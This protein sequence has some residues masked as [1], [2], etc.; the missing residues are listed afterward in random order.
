MIFLL[1]ITFFS[2]I[3]W[4]CICFWYSFPGHNVP[5]FDFNK[6]SGHFHSS[7]IQGTAIIFFLLSI[8]YGITYLLLY[9]KVHIPIS[10]KLI[11]SLAIGY[12]I[13]SNIFL[14][15]VGAVDFFYYLA[16]IKL[17][18][19]Y[20]LNPYVIT[21]N[22]L[23]N[24]TL[25]NYAAFFNIPLMYGPAW[26]TLYG[27]PTLVVNF[28][29]IFQTVIAYKFFSAFII[30][31]TGIAIFQYHE[32]KKEK[33]LALY[34]FLANP[35]ILF[36]GIGNAHNDGLMT[37]FL[38]LSLLSIKRKPILALPFITIAI[39]TKVFVIVLLPII[40][41]IIVRKK[42]PFK[43]IFISIA[44]SI[45]VI[46]IFCAPFWANGNLLSGLQK[47]AVLSENLNSGSLFSLTRE[48]YSILHIS[49]SW[50]FSPRVINTT[51]FIICFLFLFFLWTKKRISDEAAMLH[52]FLCFG[53]FVSLLFPWYLIP[54]IALLT[55]RRKF[56]ELLFLFVLSA[57]G[58]LYHPLSIWAWFN[59]GFSIFQI[60]LFQSLFMTFPI[61]FY[62]LCKLITGIFPIQVAFLLSFLRKRLAFTK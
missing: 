47:G 62:F 21:L 31:L 51:A 29:N 12:A 56:I 15:P 34:L 50:L 49:P 4:S 59:S 36:E 61:I 55:L 24:D 44:C 6:I 46:L 22:T 10:W 43:Y 20:H 54:A 14:Y 45:M 17:A 37:L 1:L 16:E 57:L 25:I 58:T 9:K 13:I 33:W 7:I 48:Y 52:I 42:M 5:Y 35:V 60:H 18:Y 2:T 8:I 28:D 41:G 32:T 23:G 11:V 39:L 53:L 40:L 19:F 3:F 27:I 38:M 26:L 30:T